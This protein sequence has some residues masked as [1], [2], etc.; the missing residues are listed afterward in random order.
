MGADHDKWGQRRLGGEGHAPAFPFGFGLGYTRIEHR[1]L[2]HRF[3]ETGGSADVRVTNTSGRQGSTVV[4]VYAADVSIHRPVAQLL[5]F[6]K[7]ALLPGGQTTV[8]VTLDA[9]PT[10]QRDPATRRW[11]PR[12]GDWALL[13]AQ[14]SPVSWTDV[15]RLRRPEGEN[16]EEGTSEGR[17]A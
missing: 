10:L 7:V 4:Q 15:A 1:V 13:A 3:D 12:A 8:R 9:G 16:D 11:S 6:R 14:N 2:N 5:G 17:A